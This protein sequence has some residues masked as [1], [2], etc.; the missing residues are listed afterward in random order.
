MDTS[1]GGDVCSGGE[2][3]KAVLCVVMPLTPASRSRWSAKQCHT[4]FPF[5]V[6]VTRR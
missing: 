5:F 2:G 6:F 1:G 3:N 4:I